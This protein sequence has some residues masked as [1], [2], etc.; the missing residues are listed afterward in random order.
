MPNLALLLEY[1]GS[2][3]AG[4]QKQKNKHTVQEALESAFFLAYKENINISAAG[5]TDAGVHALGMIVSFVAQRP[6]SDFHK[7]ISSLNALTKKGVAVLGAKEMPES[8]HA[9][10][11]CTEREYVYL[12]L[13]SKYKHPLWEGRAFRIHEKLDFEKITQEL[14]YLKG[15]HDFRSFAKTISVRNKITERHILDIQLKKSQEFPGLYAFH[16]RGTGFLHNMVR[17]IVGTLLDIGRGKITKPILEI[18]QSE[19]RTEAGTTLPPYGL[20][21]K[22]AFYKEYSEIDELYG[23]SSMLSE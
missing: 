14:S 20:Y 22:R 23:K 8:F 17:I 12:V 16:I 4:F 21:F 18:L 1:D 11:S 6:I 3:F 5:R 13:N 15:K 9:R 10:F 7:L 19:D 2:Y